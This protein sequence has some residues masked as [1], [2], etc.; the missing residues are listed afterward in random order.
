MVRNAGDRTVD[1]LRASRRPWLVAVK[2]PA[3]GNSC[4]MYG[5][6][7]HPHG[8]VRG[9][10]LA[11]ASRVFRNEHWMIQATCAVCHR[12]T[13]AALL[14]GAPVHCDGC[15]AVLKIDLAR[16]IFRRDAGE[17]G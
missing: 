8:Y 10:M 12:E 14:V 4:M 1:D 13:V 17:A 9:V 11:S 15:A 5:T 7:H 16:T 2:A 3:G 6:Q